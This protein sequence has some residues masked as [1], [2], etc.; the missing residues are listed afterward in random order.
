MKFF[1]Y[2]IE[3]EDGSLYTG[4]SNDPLKRYQKHC[5]GNGAKYTRS[6]KPKSLKMVVGFE[7]KSVAMKMEYAIKQLSHEQKQKL[8]GL[9]NTA[10]FSVENDFET[11]L[12]SFKEC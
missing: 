8:I 5:S 4:Y 7:E 9:V 2:V 6:H 10:G 12:N 1:V 3:C 11:V